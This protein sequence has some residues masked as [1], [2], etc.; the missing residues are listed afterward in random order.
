MEGEGEVT[1]AIDLL[2]EAQELPLKES[3]R[4]LVISARKPSEEVQVIMPSLE[5]YDSLLTGALS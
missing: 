3:V 5:L 2:L 1:T 4:S